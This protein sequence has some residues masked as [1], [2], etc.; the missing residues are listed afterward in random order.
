MTIID[1]SQPEFDENFM[2]ELKFDPF[3]TP[4]SNV[5]LSPNT[6]TVDIIDN[7]GTYDTNDTIPTSLK[8]YFDNST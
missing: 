7:E 8:V 4:P 2:L 6:T 1:D 3:S 5:I